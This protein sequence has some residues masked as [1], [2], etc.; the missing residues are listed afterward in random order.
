MSE[1]LDLLWELLWLSELTWQQPLRYRSGYHCLSYPVWS[2]LMSSSKMTDEKAMS[3]TVT[4]AKALGGG[5]RMAERKRLRLERMS[6]NDEGMAA[7]PQADRHFRIRD[8]TCWKRIEHPTS[9]AIESHLHPLP[10]R[11]RPRT[12]NSV[13]VDRAVSEFSRLLDLTW[14]EESGRDHPKC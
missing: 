13:D 10:L 3:T 6:W 7:A 9:N 1:P 8:P 2:V 14:F 12:E 11:H 4:V 5:C